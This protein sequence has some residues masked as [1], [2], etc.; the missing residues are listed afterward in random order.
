MKI[1]GNASLQST[2][3]NC[4]QEKKKSSKYKTYT[5]EDSAQGTRFPAE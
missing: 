1:Q 2:A 3:F 5:K 4:Q